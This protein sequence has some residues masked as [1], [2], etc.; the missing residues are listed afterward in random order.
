MKLGSFGAAVREI[1][2]DSEHD[3]FDFFGETFIVHGTIPAMLML[4]LGAFMAGELGL[5]E[6]NAVVYKALRHAL[7]VPANPGTKALANSS[8]FDKFEDLALV[9][10]CD[11][12]SLIK[13]A[14]ALTGILIDF[15]TEQPPASPDGPLQT[16]A[17]SNSS[18]SD[19]PGSPTSASDD[20]VSAG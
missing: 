20:P 2:P 7:T 19:T 8:Q 12:D 18:A 15:P 10:E 13:L 11:F 16:S 1:D 9:N 3:T 17:S 4:R 5:I 6:S 14:F